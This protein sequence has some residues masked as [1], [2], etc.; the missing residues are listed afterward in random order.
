ME[1]EEGCVGRA[2]AEGAA[3]ALVFSPQ[4][5]SGEVYELEFDTL[6]T[7]C[8]ALDIT[9]LANCSVRTVTQHVSAPRAYQAI[10]P[11]GSKEQ[12]SARVPALQLSE[13][14]IGRCFLWAVFLPTPRG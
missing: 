5:P 11:G 9:P 4:R 6:E 12:D 8:H 13:I 10:P 3:H 1:T 7:T 2:W 14:A